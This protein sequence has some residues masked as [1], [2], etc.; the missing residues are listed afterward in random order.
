MRDNLDERAMIFQLEEENNEM[1]REIALLEQQQ[2]LKK[3]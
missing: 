1:L 2:V 3:F